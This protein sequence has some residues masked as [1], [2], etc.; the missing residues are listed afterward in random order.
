MTH[1]HPAWPYPAI[2]AHRGA[3]LH[4]PENTLASM[5]LGVQHGFTMVEYDVKLSADEVPILL[6][7]DTMDRT[8]NSTGRA[9]SLSFRELSNVDFGAWHGAAYAGEPIA[10]LYAIAC[11]T[12]ANG[13]HSNIEIKPS[14]GQEARTGELVAARAAALWQHANLPPLLSSFSEI[15]LDAARAAS[16]QLPRALLI[17]GPIPRDWHN[18][19]RA[20]GCQGINIDDRETSRELVEEILARGC[21]LAVW[22][23]NTPQRARELLQWGCH[24][25]FTDD[26]TRTN[27][28][29]IGSTS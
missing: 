19:M 16:P 23:V 15:A 4:A 1:N 25:I 18:R 9:S 26:I 17:E 27:P 7:D 12:Q 21:T 14:T 29:V 8:S 20:L 11:F 6:H 13:V 5:R 2:I 22:T 3:G 24:A 28:S 10:T